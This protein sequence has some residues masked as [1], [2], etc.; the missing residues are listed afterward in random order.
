MLLSFM[1]TFSFILIFLKHPLSLGF[2]ILIQT[3]LI[4]ITMGMFYNFWYSYILFLI[5]IGGLLI[6]F[7]YMTSIASNEKFKTNFYLISSFSLIIFST[8]VN[9]IQS[10]LNL[11]NFLFNNILTNQD[12]SKYFL[13]MTKFLIFPQNKIFIFSIFYLLISMIASIKICKL[14]FGPLRQIY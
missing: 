12:N 2:F 9:L 5:M 1:M 6:L 11:N 4:S 7:I 8:T 3:I 10:N 13:S 14:N